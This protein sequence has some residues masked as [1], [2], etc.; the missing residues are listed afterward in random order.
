MQLQHATLHKIQK[1]GAVV[2]LDMYV[3]TVRVA[4]S[5]QHVYNTQI[6]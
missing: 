3:N 1:R 2:W 5:E 6:D 4:I